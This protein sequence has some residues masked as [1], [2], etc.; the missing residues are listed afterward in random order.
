MPKPPQAAEPV[1]CG[2]A[3][4]VVDDVDAA[5]VGARLKLKSRSFS[6]Y[7]SRTRRSLAVPCTCVL[8]APLFFVMCVV[9]LL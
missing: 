2:D 3:A 1:T 7:R 8:H 5:R 6:Y 9:S 4:G